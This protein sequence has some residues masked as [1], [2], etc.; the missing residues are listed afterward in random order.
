MD[1]Y[2]IYI[3]FIHTQIYRNIYLP[4]F[5]HPKID[6]DIFLLRMLKLL[7]APWSCLCRSD[8]MTKKTPRPQPIAYEF[9]F[10]V[11]TDSL[12]KWWIL[13]WRFEYVNSEENISQ[14]YILPGF[15]M[16]N[17]L[18]Q[19]SIFN[20][21]GLSWWC[22]LPETKMPGVSLNIGPLLDPRKGS[23]KKSWPP[24]ASKMLQGL[25]ALAV[26]LKGGYLEDHPS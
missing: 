14:N 12:K 22:S 4:Q 15:P 16:T 7:R 8:V 11:E 2:S 26:F 23:R 10:V 9:F 18:Y 17:H 19:R 20:F 21:G 6:I 5:S 3:Y 13:T 25:W 1:I 24:F